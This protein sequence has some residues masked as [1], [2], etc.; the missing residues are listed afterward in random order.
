V[1]STTAKEQQIE[2]IPG[3]GERSQRR[4]CIRRRSSERAGY[5]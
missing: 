2:D 3:G 1:P 5:S 4:I